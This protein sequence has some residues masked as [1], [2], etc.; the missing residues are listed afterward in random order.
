MHSIR[1][2]NTLMRRN[3]LTNAQ[4]RDLR[5]TAL[6]AASQ[7]T[8]YIFL[9]KL[10]PTAVTFYNI[11]RG[12]TAGNDQDANAALRTILLSESARICL[13]ALNECRSPR[14]RYD[15]FFRKHHLEDKVKEIEE[16][17]SKSKTI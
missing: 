13:Q 2:V 11:Y 15:Y 3:V 10:L 6:A 4:K 9:A 16:E 7:F 14:K 8:A 17:L 5:H 12:I 1:V